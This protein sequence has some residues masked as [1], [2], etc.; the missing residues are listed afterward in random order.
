VKQISEKNPDLVELR[1]DK[2]RNLHVLERIGKVKMFPL[3]ATDKSN[4]ETVEK[5]KMLL[6]AASSGF[7]YVDV[8]ASSDTTSSLVQMAK[9]FGSKVITSFHDYSGTPA[10]GDL[11]EI[12]RSEEKGPGDLFKIV[13]T[14]QHPRD[15][16][17]VLELLESK[18]PDTKLVSFAMGSLGVPS[19]V[20]SPL[21]GAEFTFAALSDNSATADGQL[22][23]DKLRGAW[24]SLGLQ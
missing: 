9:A 19:R 6:T 20:L 2:V 23:I 14:A 7:E 1:L 5:E 22:S 4:R 24:Q 21:F 17:T 8:D 15:N 12:L 18:P 10:L 13:T 3:I 16:L 11:K